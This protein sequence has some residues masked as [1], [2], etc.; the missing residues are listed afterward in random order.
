MAGEVRWLVRLRQPGISNL[1]YYSRKVDFYMRLKDE[2]RFK[3][4]QG[5]KK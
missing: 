5:D 1:G 4:V 3:L 2:E